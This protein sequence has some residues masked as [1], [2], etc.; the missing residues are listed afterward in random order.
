MQK[1]REKSL[2][3][4]SEAPPTLWME[5]WTF[6]FSSFK[7][8][9]ER[10]YR[11]FTNTNNV[12][13]M[14]RVYWL[15]K[16]SSST[17]MKISH[18]FLFILS[19][20]QNDNPKRMRRLYGFYQAFSYLDGSLIPINFKHFAFFA[21]SLRRHHSQRPNLTLRSSEVKSF[22]KVSSFMGTTVSIC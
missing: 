4:K 22:I 9:W 14:H 1:I 11:F 19:I 13:Y 16:V 8:P 21:K 20:Y 5:M 15:A 6:P 3:T 18:E 10:F 17:S 7:Y 12:Y 2:K